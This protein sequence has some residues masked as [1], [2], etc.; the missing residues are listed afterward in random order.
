MNNRAVVITLLSFFVC[1]SSRAD[2]TYNVSLN[3][4]ALIGD[5]AGPFSVAFQLTDGSFF[6]D[7]NNTVQIDNFQF[8]GGEAVPDTAVTLGNAVGDLS[9]SVTLND[10][11]FLN[12]LIQQFTPGDVLSFAV[13]ATAN[14]DSGGGV[15]QFTFSILDNTGQEIPTEGGALAR[16]FDVFL[17]INF[18]GPSP[19]IQ[20]F[21]SDPSQ[22]PGGG[23][24][25][26][27]TGMPQVALVPEPDLS[28][29]ILSLAAVLILRRLVAFRPKVRQPPEPTTQTS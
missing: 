9:S 13:N 15:D 22:T 11:S 24:S 3:T 23:G 5:V 1:V 17:A 18:D 6:G 12:F 2:V 21:E 14:V 29:L 8:G 25:P 10:S 19:T 28:P 26:I 16:F 4:A 27:I 20:T 7:G